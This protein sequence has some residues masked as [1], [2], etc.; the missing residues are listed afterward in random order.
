MVVVA[1]AAVEA[2]RPRPNR[3]T[4]LGSFQYF[5]LFQYSQYIPSIPP[6]H[7]FSRVAPEDLLCLSMH[8]NK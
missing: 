2:M 1:S 7:H 3:A 5:P 4:R 8:K 6:P